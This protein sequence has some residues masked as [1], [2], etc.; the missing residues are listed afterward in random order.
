MTVESSPV[1]RKPWEEKNAVVSGVL[2]YLIP[3]AGHFYQGRWFKG[4]IYFV[5]ILG[6]FFGGMKLGEGA[7]VYH[8]PNNR[9]G[10]SLNY[11]AQVCVGLP[12]LPAVYQTRRAKSLQNRDLDQLSAPLT[13]PFQGKL[14]T[15]G[16][17]DRSETNELVGQIE[18][19]TDL[20]GSFP[21]T[22]GKFTGTL[23]GEPIELEL[24]GGFRLERPVSA[25]FQRTLICAVARTANQHPHESQVLRGY[26]P[27]PIVD[28]YCAPPEPGQ[29]QDL[30]G[31]LGKFYDLAIAFTMIAGLLNVLAVWD[32]IEG[33]A[34]GFGDE[35]PPT[36]SETEA[37]TA[38]ATK[39]TAE[40][41]SATPPQTIR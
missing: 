4:L 24:N 26:I 9:F 23:D 27:R 10:I 18:L 1:H 2:A 33:P 37:V 32:A 30:H 41:P 17:A 15:K 12:A 36:A 5:C 3:G 21:E 29:L 11:L 19:V 28:G 13:A 6:T 25:G 8:L 7:V 34:Y 38:P 31:R 35:L 14:I 39:A 40:T 22:H 20:D 16:P